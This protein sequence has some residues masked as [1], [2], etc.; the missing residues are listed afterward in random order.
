MLGF[1]LQNRVMPRPVFKKPEVQFGWSKQAPPEYQ[2]PLTRA[3]VETTGGPTDAFVQRAVAKLAGASNDTPRFLVIPESLKVLG[4]PE[5]VYQ[6]QEKLL[7]KAA[8][9]MFPLG[10]VASGSAKPTSGYNIKRTHF[11]NREFSDGFHTARKL[12]WD[13]HKIRLASIAYGPFENV[14]GGKP[15][16]GD[17]RQAARNHPDWPAVAKRVQFDKSYAHVVDPDLKFDQ[18]SLYECIRDNY[19]LELNQL[20][21]E[22]EMPILVFNNDLDSGVVHGATFPEK[23]SPEAKRE[24]MYFHVTLKE[25]S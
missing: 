8:K 19:C 18:G 2:M 21:M 20:D 12:H 1:N 4:N 11:A 7:E 3:D 25:A 23:T 24:L 5:A 15:I 22:K 16:I 17:V 9:L 6:F 10:S 13:V 14:V